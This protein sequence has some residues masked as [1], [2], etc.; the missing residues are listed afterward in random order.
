MINFDDRL[1]KLKDRRQGTAERNRLEIGLESINADFRTN[2]NYEQLNE[3]S[4]IKYVIGSMAPVSS[5]SCIL[6]SNPIT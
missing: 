4:A 3:N 1:V 5:E 6:T 2:E